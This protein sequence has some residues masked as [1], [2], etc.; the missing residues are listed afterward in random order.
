[1]AGTRRNTSPECGG[2]AAG[3]MLGARIG[4]QASR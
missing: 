4:R 3:M 1:M 2:T